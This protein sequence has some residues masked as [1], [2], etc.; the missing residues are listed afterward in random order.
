MLIV[1]G[2]DLLKYVISN[3]YTVSRTDIDGPNAGMTMDGIQHRDLLRYR[4]KIEVKFRNLTKAEWENIE[5]NI[6]RGKEWHTVQ[7]EDFGRP[8][9][10]RM[11]HS[12]FKG[13]IS[14]IT[15]MRTGA[16]VNFIEE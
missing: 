7:F 16:D 4:R 3:N 14:T 1:D 12:S 11:Y 5:H 6:L 13:T 2:H 15:G 10:A 8:A 9:T